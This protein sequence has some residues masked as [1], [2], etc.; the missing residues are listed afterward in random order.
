MLW[1]AMVD[2]PVLAQLIDLLSSKG[3]PVGEVSGRAQQAMDALGRAS[4]LQALSSKNPWQRLKATASKPTIQFKF[5]KPHE[6]AAYIEQQA[7]QAF[8]S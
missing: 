3:V 2:D 4:V 5:L 8:W 6:L 7:K 1:W